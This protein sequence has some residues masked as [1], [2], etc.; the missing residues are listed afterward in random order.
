MLMAK[1]A[2]SDIFDNKNGNLI[3]S[4]NKH[5]WDENKKGVYFVGGF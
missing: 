3:Y 1:K 2:I 4:N 5:F